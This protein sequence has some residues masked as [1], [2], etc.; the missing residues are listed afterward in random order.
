MKFKI[1]N[2]FF[3]T[4]DKRSRNI[5]KE[6]NMNKFNKKVKLNYIQ[7]IILQIIKIII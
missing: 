3:N 5:I 2:R 4:R 7:H 6:N 1:L